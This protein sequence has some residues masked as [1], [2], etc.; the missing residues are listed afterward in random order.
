MK[1]IIIK[2]R[3]YSDAGQK[4]V[5]DRLTEEFSTR[6]VEIVLQNSGLLSYDEN[7]DY[8]LPYES[9]DFVLFFD[10]DIALSRALEKKYRVFNSTYTLVACDDKEKTYAEIEG[11]G[12]KIPRTIMS[13]LMYQSNN[14]VDNEFENYVCKELG[15]PMII[16]ENIGSL[17]MQV[18]IANNSAEVNSIRDKLKHIPHMYQKYE[19]NYGK[20]IRTYIVGGKVI[21]ACRRYNTGSYVSNMS[22]GGKMELIEINQEFID[23]AQII[24]NKLKMDYGSVDFVDS[25]TPI[26][27]EANSNA[28]F[29]AIEKLGVNIAAPIAEYIIKSC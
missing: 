21:A 18:Y 28:Y 23:I 8:V 25:K 2:N 14:N 13:P 22:A 3:Y 11:L 5:L 9:A 29:R 26:F 16:K 6:G 12:I 15:F 17:G 1:G 10:K 24:A 27:L 4:Y 20:D 19:G 7:G